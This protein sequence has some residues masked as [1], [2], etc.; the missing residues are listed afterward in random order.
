M[1]NLRYL[2]LAGQKL[3]VKMNATKFV[4]WLILSVKFIHAID[5]ENGA[6]SEITENG[7]VE[8]MGLSNTEHQIDTT[9]WTEQLSS[10]S[11]FS[12]ESTT[13]MDGDIESGSETEAQTENQ[14]EAT[15]E[16]EPE[17]VTEADIEAITEIQSNVEPKS[18]NAIKCRDGLLFPVWRPIENITG[19]DR[20]ARGLVYFLALCYLFLGVSIVSDRFMAS[21]EK[22]TAIEKTVSVRKPDGTKQMIVVRVWNETVANLTLMALGTS[23][24]EILLS[25]IEIFT[26]HFNA[27]E[28]GPSTIVGSAAYN[29]FTIIALC[30]VVIPNNE[31]RRIKHLRVFFVTATWSVFAYI[32]L[33]LILAFFTPG[34]VSVWEGVITFLFFPL[35]VWM[36]YAADRRLLM[37][38]YLSKGFRINE[39]GVMIQMESLS[40]SPKDRSGSVILDDGTELFSEDFKDPECIR[41]EYVSILQELRQKH[42]QYDRDTLETMAQEQLLNSGPKSHAFYR[43][44]AGRKILGGGNVIRRIAERTTNEVKADLSQVEVVDDDFSPKVCFEPNHYTVMENCGSVDIRVVRLGDFSGSVSVD[45]QTQDGSAEAGMDYIAQSGTITFTPGISERFIQIDIIDDEIFEE[46]ESFFIQLNNPTNGAVL[47]SASLATIMILD[48]D[49]AGFFSFAEKSHELIETVGIYELKVVRTSG[50]RGTVALP[51]WTE[52]ATAKSGKA[53]EKQSDQLIF[54]NNETE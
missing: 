45:Y 31:I 12:D 40:P 27:G 52:D 5:L 14:T 34:V 37:Y 9:P 49:H 7:M 4:L 19:G 48:D 10:T 13:Q 28:L 24:P 2:Q 36:A 54:I 29:L 50:A 47:G 43:I 21:I 17:T 38:K 3:Q 41:N 11:V 32:W 26:N 46:D 51:Y 35:I 39:R 23:A 8:S 20:F 16:S 53:Y 42:P 15:T 22:I 1:F 25:I 18:S 30:I 33:Y 6:V 44:Q